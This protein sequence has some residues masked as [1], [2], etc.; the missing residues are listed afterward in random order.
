MNVRRDGRTEDG[1]STGNRHTCA[2]IPRRRIRQPLASPAAAQPV[3]QLPPVAL[4]EPASMT[5]QVA[6]VR[7]IDDGRRIDDATEISD[8]R[9]RELRMHDRQQRDQRRVGFVAQRFERFVPSSSA[10]ICAYSTRR[11]SAGAIQ[12]TVLRSIAS[13]RSITAQVRSD[14][15]KSSTV[16]TCAPPLRS[17]TGSTHAS[18]RAS[19]AAAAQATAAR[20]G[21]DTGRSHRPRRRASHAHRARAR[22]AAARRPAFERARQIGGRQHAKARQQGTHGPRRHHSRPTRDAIGQRAAGR[23]RVR[24]MHERLPRHHAAIWVDARRPDVHLRSSRRT[25][26]R[27]RRRDRQECRP[28]ASALAQMR[29]ETMLFLATSRRLT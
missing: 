23:V 14:S 22:A 16:R 7:D 2:A 8:F 24:S 20:D 17:T 15:P 6:V 18:R 12:S 10:S 21:R 26:M 27:S 29:D 3:K 5:D 1:G 9:H 19:T 4:A 11:A 25:R 28:P 13:A